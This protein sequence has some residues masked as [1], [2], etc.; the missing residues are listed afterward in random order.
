VIV[1]GTAGGQRRTFHGGLNNLLATLVTT[2][3]ASDNCKPQHPVHCDVS[4]PGRQWCGRGVHLRSHAGQRH[5]SSK[6]HWTQMW[7]GAV[8]LLLVAALTRHVH[9]QRECPMPQM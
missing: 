7:G 9:A 1:E 3:S 2:D 8:Q 6:E 5:K 4:T